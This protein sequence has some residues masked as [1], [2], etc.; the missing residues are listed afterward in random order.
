MGEAQ[1][2]MDQAALHGD[3]AE[4]QREKNDPATWSD[5]PTATAVA[6]RGEFD[7]I[8]FALPGTDLDVV[9][10]DHCRDPETGEID[11]W[12]DAWLHTAN[13][14]YVELT[15]SGEGLRIIG[16]GS[17][18]K[19]HRKWNVEGERDGAAIEIYRCAERY[20]TVTGQQ[21]GDCTALASANGLLEHIQAHYD[22]KSGAKGDGHDFND[23]GKQGAAFDYD[24]VIRNGAPVGS[25]VSAVF[26]SVVGHLRVQGMSLEE[27]VEELGRHAGGIG[28]RYPGR[29]RK[30]V[31]RSFRKWGQRSQ[32]KAP[33]PIDDA[34][35]PEEPQ[36]WDSVDKNR[37][38][39][40]TCTNA[41]RA[42][43]ALGIKCRYDIFHD[44]L[45]IDSA[46]IQQRTNLDQTVLILRTKIHKA[47]GFDPGTKN[48][49]DALVQLCLEHEFDPVVDYLGALAWDGVERLDKW[50]VT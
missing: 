4:E 26:H 28:A 42:L 13:G 16:L 39:R 45:L 47:F 11:P 37:N 5:Y 38:P 30:E 2:R 50:T 15:P 34:A 8:G 35:E 17:G 32:I 31:E 24:D 40:P 19:V 6:Q 27:I 29:L 22:G 43:R 49:T 20:I 1:G 25:D 21:I 7:G 23:A 12:A 46:T 41:R 10:L 48:T 33:P 44:K 3:G 9:D 36:A 14:A 18:G